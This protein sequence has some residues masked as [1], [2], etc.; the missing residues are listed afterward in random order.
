MLDDLNTVLVSPERW[1]INTDLNI[2]IK[3]LKNEKFN[4]DYVMTDPENSSIWEANSS[5]FSYKI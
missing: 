2:F 1:D 5:I 4:L 3:K